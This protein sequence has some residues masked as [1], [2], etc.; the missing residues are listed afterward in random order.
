MPTVA[1]TAPERDSVMARI[2][3]LMA[4]SV[5]LS[6]PESATSAPAFLVPLSQD[7]A[8]SNAAA[9]A[10]AATRK[11][12][13]SLRPAALPSR[14]PSKEFFHTS[15]VIFTPAIFFG[16]IKRR[17]F[18]ILKPAIFFGSLVYLPIRSLLKCASDVRRAENAL[19]TISGT[20]R[21]ALILRNTV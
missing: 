9:A 18:G 17:A 19:P 21:G 3:P 6:C 5:G 13:S 1:L 12:A 16:L 14:S 20:S 4:S 2:A 8:V 7:A 10:A 11:S 15:F